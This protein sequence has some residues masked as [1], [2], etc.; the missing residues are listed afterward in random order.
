MGV[1]MAAPARGDDL[2]ATL[3]S[4]FERRAEPLACQKI[5]LKAEGH[6]QSHCLQLKGNEFFYWR[7]CRGAL[8]IARYVWL[9]WRIR[10]GHIP[11]A[12]PMLS[13]ELH[14]QTGG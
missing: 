2:A 8:S 13:C 6:A 14:G 9:L 7:S 3:A 5:V 12:L 4:A 11:V 10:W 1:R